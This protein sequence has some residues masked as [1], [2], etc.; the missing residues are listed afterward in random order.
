MAKAK[1]KKI[2]FYYYKVTYQSVAGEAY[3]PNNRFRLND[4]VK[5]VSELPLGERVIDYDDDKIKLE[6]YRS[7]TEGRYWFFNF[8]KLRHTE[9]P[10]KAY[11]DKVAEDLILNDDEFIGEPAYALYDIDNGILMLQRNVH[12]VSRRVLEYYLNQVWK[13]QN[14]KTIYLEPITDVDVL[15]HVTKKGVIH[16]QLVVHVSGQDNARKLTQGSLKSYVQGLAGLGGNEIKLIISSGRG[17]G[18][19]DSEAIIDIV[20]QIMENRDLIQT[21]QMRIKDGDTT[22][23]PLDLFSDI[24][25]EEISFSVS[26]RKTLGDNLVEDKMYERYH[27]SRNKLNQHPRE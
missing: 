23:R 22:V 9:L 24:L 6:L 16:R 13:G 11:I 3:N 8:M 20:H 2:R 4:W 14:G 15:A 12:G 5:I 18:H 17:H 7:N 10:K 1:T 21:A 27:Q 26:P 25:H 19:L